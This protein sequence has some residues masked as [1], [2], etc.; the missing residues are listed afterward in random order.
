MHAHKNNLDKKL[1]RRVV[2]VATMVAILAL[3]VAVPLMTNPELRYDLAMKTNSVPGK[4]VEKIAD[5]DAGEILIII[6]LDHQDDRLITSWLFRA[7]FISRPTESGIDLENLETGESITMPLSE[8]ERISANADGSLVLFIGTESESGNP[9]AMTVEPS[10]MQIKEL[11]N[12]DSVPDA[13]GDWATSIW[14]KQEG[15][16]H[17]GSPNRKFL[18]CFERSDLASYF[19]GDWQLNLQYWGDYEQQFPIFRGMGFLPFVGFAENDRVL[20]FQNENGIWRTSLPE[21]VLRDAPDGVPFATPH[22]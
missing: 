5:G 22:P 21:N 7:Q 12:A 19:A 15:Q 18:V 14:A 11:P 6:P 13:S 4:T 16:C 20:Y 17:A 9:V 10:T 8:I 2:I 1:Q 3:V